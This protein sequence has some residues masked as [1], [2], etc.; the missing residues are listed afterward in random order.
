MLLSILLL[1]LGLI[2]LTK[3][4]D[5]FVDG[6][7]A[8]AQKF[9]IPSII[10]GLTIV[11]MG[12]SAPEASVSIVSALKGANGVAIGNVL[13]SNIAN[14]FLIL[15][16]TSSICALTIQKNT[17]KY[18]IPFVGFITVLVCALGYYFHSIN[19]YCA[20]ILLAF[21]GLF[22]VYLFKV[23]FTTFCNTIFI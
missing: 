16:V 15:G 17:I 7:C 5:F 1:I 2:M 6:A 12:T 23:Y 11:A 14:I 4:A 3:G 21:F 9:K 8:L 20:L 22:F 19:R 10:I 13:G 18:E